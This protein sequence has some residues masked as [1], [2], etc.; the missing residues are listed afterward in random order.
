MILQLSVESWD[1]LE[2]THLHVVLHSDKE[3]V[4]SGWM[5]CNVQVMKPV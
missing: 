5:M 1:S 4:P 2:L 3:M